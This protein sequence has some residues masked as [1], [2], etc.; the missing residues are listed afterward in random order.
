MINLKFKIPV[1]A[2][3]MILFL[4][5]C[6]HENTVPETVSN[7]LDMRWIKERELYDEPESAA[8]YLEIIDA[9]L[10]ELCKYY[11]SSDSCK[12]VSNKTEEIEKIFCMYI[13]EVNS[14]KDIVNKYYGTD[15][16]N[17]KWREH[18]IN[19]SEL[20]N[21]IHKINNVNVSSDHKYQLE[22][23]LNIE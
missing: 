17:L 8:K 4:T 12:D 23:L 11:P 6:K 10:G 19:R 13:K 1:L 9:E 2:L 3:L 21:K 7:G 5:S 16:F 20:I 18:Q 14:G 15:Y 22:A